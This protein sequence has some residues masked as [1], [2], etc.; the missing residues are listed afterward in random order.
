IES[1]WASLGFFFLLIPAS[2]AMLPASL[3][4][5]RVSAVHLIRA[6]TYAFAILTFIG[7]IHLTQAVV[8]LFFPFIPYRTLRHV[9][10]SVMVAGACW[11]GVYWWSAVRSFEIR[12]PALV[13]LA[14]FVVAALCSMLVTLVLYSAT[15]NVAT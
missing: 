3:R 4:H 8:S 1:G 13:A 7:C 9:E 10:W 5:A 2:L 15:V 14:M 12:R 11:V 6:G